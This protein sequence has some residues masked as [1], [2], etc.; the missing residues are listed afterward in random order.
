MQMAAMPLTRGTRRVAVGVIDAYVGQQ[1]LIEL[2]F[3]GAFKLQQVRTAEEARGLLASWPPVILLDAGQ[4]LDQEA[5]AGAVKKLRDDG[6]EGWILVMCFDDD[7]RARAVA[8]DRLERARPLPK[9]CIADV[10]KVVNALL[11]RR[12]C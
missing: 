5:D 2:L 4:P 12:G 1:R 9:T 6:F 7:A 10:D 8:A 3:P 11:A